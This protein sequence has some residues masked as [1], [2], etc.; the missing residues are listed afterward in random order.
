MC[1][2]CGC[3]RAHDDMGKP[4]VN[5]T[6]EDLKRAADASGATVDDILQT[7]AETADQGPPRPPGRVRR[8][9]P[10]SDPPELETSRPVGL[11]DD[12]PVENRPTDVTTDGQTYGG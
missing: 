9:R 7:I 10:S 6:Y 5:I 8:W 12:Q 1:L 4:D 3:M 2:N 11:V